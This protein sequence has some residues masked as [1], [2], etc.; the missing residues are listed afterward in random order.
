MRT[1]LSAGIGALALAGAMQPAAAA[2]LAV[3]APVYKA[4]PPVYDLWTGG[5]IGVN[6]GY[7]WGPW[8]STSPFGLATTVSPKVNGWLGGVQAGYNWRFDPRWAVGFE[9]DIQV[10]GERASADGAFASARIPEFGADFN[11]IFT[12]RVS[13]NWKFPWFATLRGR[14]GAL[15]DPE[16]LFYATG[17]LAVGEFKLSSSASV[18]CQQF[19]PGSLGTIPSGN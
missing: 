10:T 14:I 9:G 4:P 11:D 6:V 18:T 3:K 19:G 15:V 17:G 12:T 8:D 5:Y 1:I 16:T 13:N 7:S 2:D